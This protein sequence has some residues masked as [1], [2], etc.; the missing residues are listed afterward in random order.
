MNGWTTAQK[1]KKKYAHKHINC[2]YIRKRKG[3]MCD[4]DHNKLFVLV[5]IACLFNMNERRKEYNNKN[6]NKIKWM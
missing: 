2:I 6:N 4:S 1:W 5:D 3:G